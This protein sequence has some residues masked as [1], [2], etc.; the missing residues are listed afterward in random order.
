[1]KT[2]GRFTHAIKLYASHSVIIV[3]TVTMLLYLLKSTKS[4]FNCLALLQIISFFD[5]QVRV[6][7]QML[8][9]KEHNFTN[10]GETNTFI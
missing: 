9:E 4:L 2:K 7:L 1:M 3:A 8:K 10:L 6:K 5:F